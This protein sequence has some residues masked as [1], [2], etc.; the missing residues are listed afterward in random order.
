MCV[1]STRITCTP[2]SSCCACMPPLPQSR[3]Q[4]SQASHLPFSSPT[5]IDSWPRPDVHHH[6]VHTAILCRPPLRRLQLRPP[7][8]YPLWQVP[9]LLRHSSRVDVGGRN[10][11][12]AAATAKATHNRARGTQGGAL[13]AVAGWD[14]A[15]GSAV[16]RA[17]T[18]PSSPGLWK[19]PHHA[20]WVHIHK[21]LFLHNCLLLHH[22]LLSRG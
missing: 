13:Q 2:H 21:A 10:A 20:S 17:G 5:C 18:V 12:L 16:G 15:Q 1:C 7:K 8:V 19:K 6:L 14:L 3:R 22:L 9:Q 4:C 11:Q